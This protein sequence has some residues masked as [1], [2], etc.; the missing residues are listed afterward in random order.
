MCL[1]YN[2]LSRIVGSGVSTYIVLG[3]CALDQ[4]FFATQQDGIF[5][6]LCAFQKTEHLEAV[7][8][9]VKKNFLTTWLNDCSIWPIVNFVGFAWV[10]SV[11]LPTYMSLVQLFWQ[12]YVSSVAAGEDNEC[13]DTDDDIDSNIGTF[14]DSSPVA[15]T[16]TTKSSLASCAKTKQVCLDIADKSSMSNNSS[17]VADTVNSS[18]TSK[19]NSKSLRKG[20]MHALWRWE[21]DFIYSLSPHSNTVPTPSSSTPISTTATSTVPALSSSSSSSS[22]T[23]VSSPSSSSSST[24][25]QKVQL[26]S[27]ETTSATHSDNHHDHNAFSDSVKHAVEILEASEKLLAKQLDEHW[28]QDRQSALNNAKIGGSLLF[29]AAIIRKLVFK[30]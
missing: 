5:L 23:S 9:K 18:N 20:I 30:I 16:T 1:W 2:T 3:K 28:H 11:L 26:S 19:N 24:S 27:S 7:I 17:T 14:F 8:A 13:D 10:P 25:P 15:A 21:Q 29:T 6:T 12:I 4:I 22:T